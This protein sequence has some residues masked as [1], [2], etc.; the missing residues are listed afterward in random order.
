M[1]TSLLS[2]I[3]IAAVAFTS[4]KKETHQLPAAQPNP[5]LGTWSI[6]K[7][8]STTYDANGNPVSTAAYLQPLSSSN[9]VTFSKDSTAKWNID[10]FY[11]SSETGDAGVL[12]QSDFRLSGYVYS[13][14]GKTILMSE[15]MGPMGAMGPQSLWE[16]E[17]A[18]LESA[19][20]LVIHSVYLIGNT[21]KVMADT[22]YTK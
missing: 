5:L 7:I 4:C 3:A 19:N 22:Y 2:L 6:V 17:S 16:S 15:P 21:T 13:V 8:N 1:R 10:H 20:S 18:T 11:I 14:Q 12:Q 9:Y